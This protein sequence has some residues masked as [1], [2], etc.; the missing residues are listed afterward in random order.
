MLATWLW[1]FY[2][3]GILILLLLCLVT[4]VDWAFSLPRILLFSLP[5]ST[6]C[7]VILPILPVWLLANQCFIKTI[8][9]T[10][11]Y[12]I[13]D[14]CS[15]AI[16]DGCELPHGGWQWNSGPLKKQPVFLPVAPSPQRHICVS[17]SKPFGIFWMPSAYPLRFSQYFVPQKA[18]LC[19]LAQWSPL[20]RG[21]QQESVKL[22]Y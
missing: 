19:K 4:T 22:K 12:R 8:Q 15:T 18:E 2:K 6:S 21:F 7:L 1:T 17:S 9:V 11:L 3:R 16:T 10:N 14:H 20:A 13:E 5:T